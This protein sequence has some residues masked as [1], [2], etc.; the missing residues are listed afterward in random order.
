MVELFSSVLDITWQENIQFSSIASSSL[1][2]HKSHASL[3]H[4]K[5]HYF[6]SKQWLLCC[7]F[8]IFRLYTQEIFCFQIKIHNARSIII[9]PW[10]NFHLTL[11]DYMGFFLFLAKCMPGTF[12][13]L[14]HYLA[15]NFLLVYVSDFTYN[16]NLIFT[17][18]LF[19]LVSHYRKICTKLHPLSHCLPPF[20]F[21]FSNC[22]IWNNASFAIIILY[23]PLCRTFLWV[24]SLKSFHLHFSPQL[25]FML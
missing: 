2:S 5:I 19:Q 9:I 1:Y 13:S 3:S 22:K 10:C 18:C 16:A 15:F 11:L 17:N 8:W 4:I 14:S 24:F 21:F 7:I 25:V 12:F 6:S 20:V 23:D